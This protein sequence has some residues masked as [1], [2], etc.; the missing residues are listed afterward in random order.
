MSSQH[1]QCE[2]LTLA[3][4]S[5]SSPDLCPGAVVICTDTVFVDV[6]VLVS[7]PPQVWPDPQ[8]IILFNTFVLVSDFRGPP[9]TLQE[10]PALSVPLGMLT[11]ASTPIRGRG[12]DAV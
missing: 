8:E 1:L 11:S 9:R 12:R 10:I 3:H 4:C 7:L 6:P 5:A 2:P